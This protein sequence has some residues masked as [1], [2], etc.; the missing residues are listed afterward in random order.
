[1][2]MGYSLLDRIK[3]KRVITIL[4]FVLL[5]IL[6]SWIWSALFEYRYFDNFDTSNS[7]SLREKKPKTPLYLSLRERQIFEW[8]ITR[9]PHN[10]M[11]HWNSNPPHESPEEWGNEGKKFKGVE[12][13]L[14]K[15]Y[16]KSIPNGYITEVIE[17]LGYV[18]TDESLAW[19][20]NRFKETEYVED[21][22]KFIWAIGMIGGKKAK[23]MLCEIVMNKEEDYIVQSNAVLGLSRIA[24]NGETD[25]LDCIKEALESNTITEEHT[26]ETAERYLNEYK[27]P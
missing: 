15:F 12:K 14:I 25:A 17:A 5:C 16:D 23:N 8:V 22:R 18:G 6:A 4:L 11:R 27:L 21:R 7:F 20:I 19:L 1:M 13:T 24:I 9:P 2:R 3:K 10:P 26:R